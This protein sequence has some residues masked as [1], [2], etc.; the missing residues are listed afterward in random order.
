MSLNEM[1]GEANAIECRTMSHHVA[2]C[3]SMSQ[4]IAVFGQGSTAA[5]GF[6]RVAFGLGRSKANLGT[7]AFAVQPNRSPSLDLVAYSL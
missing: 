4:H 6:C 7:A 5:L 2:P 1:H 3:R